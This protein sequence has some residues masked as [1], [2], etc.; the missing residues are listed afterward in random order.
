MIPGPSGLLNINSPCLKDY[1][2][3]CSKRLLARLSQMKINIHHIAADYPLKIGHNN[4]ECYYLSLLL[5]TVRGPASF[6]FLKIVDDTTYPTFHAAYRA[7]HLLDCDQHWGE[8]LKEAGDNHISSHMRHLIAVML[9][10]CGLS[11]PLELW[12]KYQHHLSEDLLRALRSN[13]S[14]DIAETDECIIKSCLCHLDWW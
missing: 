6:K 5:H 11:S 9:V 8:T 4:R 14:N 13:S 10:F 2:E 12:D 7:H 1:H 3:M